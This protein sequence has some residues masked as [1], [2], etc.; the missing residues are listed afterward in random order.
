MDIEV[1]ANLFIICL[2]GYVVGYYVGKGVA[3][4]YGK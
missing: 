4:N 1:L 3:N 2:C